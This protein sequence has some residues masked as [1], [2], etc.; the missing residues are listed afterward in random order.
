[1]EAYMYQEALGKHDNTKANYRAP[2]TEPKVME[3][4]IAWQ[5]IQNNYL[6]EAGCL[7]FDSFNFLTF[8]KE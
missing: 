4:W 7:S 1:M 2:L 3:I 5:R 6:K 8:K